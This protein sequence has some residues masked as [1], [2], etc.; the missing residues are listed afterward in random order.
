MLYPRTLL[1]LAFKEMLY[2]TS[3]KISNPVPLAPS[4]VV[5]DGNTHGEI[6]GVTLIMYRR[7]QKVIFLKKRYY[8]ITVD[9]AIVIWLSQSLLIVRF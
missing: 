5:K 7:P 3:H 2:D 1:T 8:A 9:G 4:G 6:Y